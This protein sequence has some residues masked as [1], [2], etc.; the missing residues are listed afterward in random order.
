M[1]V[2][3]GGGSVLNRADIPQAPRPLT[4]TSGYST[5]DVHRRLTVTSL[6]ARSTTDAF[7]LIIYSQS[8]L[9]QKDV[10]T[11]FGDYSK[12]QDE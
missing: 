6:G 12:V 3:A 9:L 7:R 1:R 11:V 8:S 2:F 5:P 4:L 10:K